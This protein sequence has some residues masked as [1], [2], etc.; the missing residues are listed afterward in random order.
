[1]GRIRD[2][3]SVLTKGRSVMA[4]WGWRSGVS[5]SSGGFDGAKFRG[6]LRSLYP[7]GSDLDAEALRAQSRSAYWDSSQ[8]RAAVRRIG[9]SVVGTGLTLRSTPLWMLIGSTLDDEGQRKL[10]D[11]I[12]ERFRLWADSHEP[13]A[14]GRRNLAEMQSFIFDNE[15]RDGDLPIVLRYSG[16]SSRL[17]PLNLQVLDADQ[18][19]M[20]VTTYGTP[21]KAGL[22]VAAAARGNIL[23][24]G[25]E[26]TMAGE[27]VAI[28]VLNPARPYDK[29]TRVPAS[30]PSGR[31]FVL[32]PSI[33]DLPG[34][35]RGVGPLAP[36]VH[37]LQK[38]TDYTVAE[39]E[40]AV[41]NA[42]IAGMIEPGAEN[43][44]RTDV[45]KSLGVS[46]RNLS[47]TATAAGTTEARIDKPGLWVGT[48]KAGEKLASFDTKRPNVNFGTFVQTVTKS[49]SASLSLPVEVL[50]MAFSANYSASRASLILFWNTVE[51]WRAHVVS[52][53][54]QPIYEAWLREEVS[55]GRLPILRAT[56]F[57]TDPVQTRAWMQSEWI[58][59]PMPSIDPVKDADAADKRIA[60]GATTRERN[61]L[62]FNKSDFYENAARQKREREAMPTET[63]ASPFGAP[64]PVQAPAQQ[65]NSNDNQ[66]EAYQ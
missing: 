25:L 6:A 48:L 35:V 60:Q 49:L 26:M 62:E 28:Y 34:Q 10:A 54:L 16:D 11:E 24:D 42:T 32:L 14:T 66:Q 55:S 61:A 39:I 13:D 8:A 51:R 27:L 1:M 53:F 2:A 20:R 4:S 58:G 63:A 15:L 22:S 19:D 3:L 52:Q 18:L 43:D 59:D 46:A 5:S 29:P 21:D 36:I 47:S 41:Q 23:K 9:D 7:S 33:L 50:E 17:S 45:Q 56:G 31:R 44:T 64:S 37:E 65:D 12:D 30:G 40:A 38:I 57:G